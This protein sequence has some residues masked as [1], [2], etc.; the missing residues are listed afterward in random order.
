MYW[1]FV[2]TKRLSQFFKYRGTELIRIGMFPLLEGIEPELLG[3]LVAQLQKCKFVSADRNLELHA[4]HLHIRKERDYR[5]P[6]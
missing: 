1:K 2:H 4:R 6:A 3:I 5:F